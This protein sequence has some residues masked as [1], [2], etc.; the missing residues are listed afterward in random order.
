MVIGFNSIFGWVSNTVKAGGNVQRNS[1]VL[2][3][4]G[5]FGE[6]Q[7]FTYHDKTDIEYTLSF[8][9]AL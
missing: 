7:E 9:M 5:H 2:V 8:L 6:S 3:F 4:H 1:V